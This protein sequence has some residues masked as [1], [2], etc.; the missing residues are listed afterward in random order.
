MTTTNITVRKVPEHVKQA[1]R[2]RA[3]RRGRSLEE[4][5]RQILLRAAGEAETAKPQNLA[6][7]IAA[8]TDPL[9]GI[10]LDIPE[11]EP[12]PPLPQFDD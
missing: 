2:V 1:L 12:P 7:A 5:V 4:E 3:A 6:E 8:I 11:R 9:G 10:E